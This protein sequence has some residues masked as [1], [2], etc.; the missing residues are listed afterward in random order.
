MRPAEPTNRP[1]A[2]LH[3]VVAELH[4]IA[5]DADA[6]AA[7]GAELEPEVVKRMIGNPEWIDWLGRLGIDVA[8]LLDPTA[9]PAIV[10]GVTDAMRRAAE[11][12]DSSPSDVQ[13]IHNGL[14]LIA[15]IALEAVA[16]C[17]SGAPAV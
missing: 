12:L 16:D 6:L 5:E 17:K 8:G 2:K 3:E 4:R 9:D 7:S 10:Q 15:V 11:R 13:G 14:S 1:A